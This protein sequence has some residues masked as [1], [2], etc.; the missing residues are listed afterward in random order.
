MVARCR[1][2]AKRGDFGPL[3]DIEKT[4]KAKPI[5]LQLP[6]GLGDGFSGIIDLIKSRDARFD[7]KVV[8]GAAY[9]NMHTANFP[10]GEIRGQIEGN[11]VAWYQVRMGVG[12]RA[13]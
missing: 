10:S 9:A 2:Q 12:Y 1:F 4:L 11:K 13:D 5:A 6:I 7:I 8:P 3:D